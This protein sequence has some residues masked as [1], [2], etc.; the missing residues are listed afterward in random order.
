MTSIT[1]YKKLVRNTNKTTDSRW[2]DGRFKGFSCG[3]YR[4]GDGLVR[5][6]RFTSLSD[7]ERLANM[8][9]TL[10]RTGIMLDESGTNNFIINNDDITYLDYFL[11]SASSFGMSVCLMVEFRVKNGDLSTYWFDIKAKQSSALAFEYLAK[12]YK[13]NPTIVGFEIMNEPVVR[14]YPPYTLTLSSVTA[15]SG[16]TATC[17]GAIFNSLFVGKVVAFV[18]TGGKTFTITGYTDANTVVGTLSAT[19]STN[20]YASGTWLVEFGD[21]TWRDFAMY[22]I[23]TIRAH[24]PERTIVVSPT[25]YSNPSLLPTLEPFPYDNL[26]YTVHNYQP[27]PF[28][29]QGVNGY[30]ILTTAG[31]NNLYPGHVFNGFTWDKSYIS[32]EIY[33]PIRDFKAA[34]NVPIWMGEFSCIY[35]ADPDSRYNYLKDHLDLLNA[36]GY[37]W[38]MQSQG[39]YIGWDYRY[40]RVEGIGGDVLVPNDRLGELIQRYM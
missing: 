4:Y 7:F 31:G 12:R 3:G 6:Q 21:Q 8:G 14:G 32:S 1:A 18:G 2:V 5:T 39:D 38:T 24:D 15:G 36:E 29:H 27:M 17:T 40:Q 9:C 34:H 37:N 28:T 30:P 10:L 35:F 11:A 13:D 25:G 20:T 16:I 22:S 19:V 26:V 33:Q 23:N